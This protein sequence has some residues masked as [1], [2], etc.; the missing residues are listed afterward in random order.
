M[1]KNGEG[2][3]QLI[4]DLG[5]NSDDALVLGNKRRSQPWTVK[6]WHSFGLD[7]NAEQ[8]K[9]CPD[10]VVERMET[11]HRDLMNSN[12]SSENRFD[13]EIPK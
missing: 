5:I 7:T 9:P 3:R 1:R 8:W 10:N 12:K 2:L 11:V 13:L 6:Q 4:D